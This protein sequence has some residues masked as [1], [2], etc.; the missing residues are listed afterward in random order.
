M[1]SVL[2]T[3]ADGY[4]GS[5]IIAR[6]GEA[7]DGEIIAAVHAANDADLV[8]RRA[9]LRARFPGAPIRV[10]SLDLAAPD[11]CVALHAL[12]GSIEYIVHA[13][14][15]T[16]FDVAREVATVIN[17]DGANAVWRFAERCTRLRAA[18]HLSTVYATGLHEGEIREQPYDDDA[19]FANHYEWSKWQAEDDIIREHGHL[20]MRIARVA[21]VLADDDSGVVTRYN[22]VHHTLKLLYR[23]LLSVLPGLANVPVHL[24]TGDFAAA[25]ILDLLWRPDATGVFHV[26][27]DVT[28]AATLGGIL[29]IA[30]DQWARDPDF[31]ARRVLPP[32]FADRETF[33]LLSQGITALGAGDVSRTLARMAS[34]APQLYVAKLLANARMRAVSRRYE[35]PDQASVI[36]ATCR[37][38]AHT[39]W[40]RASAA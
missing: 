36:A 8:R 14:A 40:R 13:A 2:I 24:V 16:R 5:R 18:C 20:P 21:T 35:P 25:A 4:L 7:W 6:L 34:F 1:N 37:S 32:L 38:L 12:A 28:T 10:F 31:H 22:V 11:P 29:E 23:G 39:Q 9:L 19:G 26:A 15:V 30:F 27:H 3:G 33:E 17:V